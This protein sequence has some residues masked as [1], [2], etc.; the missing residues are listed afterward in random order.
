MGFR[1]YID[2]FVFMGSDGFCILGYDMIVTS[3]SILL[4]TMRGLLLGKLLSLRR[5]THA[6]IGDSP[7]S[8][9]EVGH[10]CLNL[11]RR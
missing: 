4:K 6:S 3:T 8:E 9:L 7:Q 5:P 11:P 1:A 2:Y 10:S